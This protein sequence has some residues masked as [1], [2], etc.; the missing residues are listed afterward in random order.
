MNW[1]LIAVLAILAVFTISGIQRGIVK[2]IF[3][4]VSLIGTLIAVFILLPVVSDVIKNNTKIYENLE[5]IVSEKVLPKIE[6]TGINA[7]EIIDSMDVPEVIKEIIQKNN[8]AEKYIELGVTSLQE[9]LTKSVTDIIFNMGAFLT[10]F[11]IVFIIF[12][13][14]FGF[15]TILT[16]LPLIHSANKL[17]GG[18]AGFVM[19]ISLIWFILALLTVFG[20]TEFAKE[21]FEKVNENEVLTFISNNNFIMKYVQIIMR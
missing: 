10:A 3:P 18:V 16:E 2:M 5:Q 8:Y 12:R 13:I 1:V 21:V 9:Y 17:A 15:M 11:L 20:S 4:I 14:L 6:Y 19:G 7:D